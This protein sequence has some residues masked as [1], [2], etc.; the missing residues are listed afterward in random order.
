MLKINIS[1]QCIY[2]EVCIWDFVGE[3]VYED[4]MNNDSEGI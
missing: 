1:L 4:I 3:L 2:I